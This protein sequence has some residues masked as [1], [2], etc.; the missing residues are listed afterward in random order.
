MT[1]K[2]F[3][4]LDWTLITIAAAFPRASRALIF[5]QRSRKLETRLSFL[6]VARYAAQSENQR[7]RGKIL[8]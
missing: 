8:I 7:G 3:A 4:R 1:E 2:R 5:L 6:A